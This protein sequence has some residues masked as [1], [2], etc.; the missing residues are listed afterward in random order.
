M[1]CL[2]DDEIVGVSYEYEQE[3]AGINAT[4]IYVKAVRIAVSFSTFFLYK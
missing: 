4:E 1:S 3:M 2:A